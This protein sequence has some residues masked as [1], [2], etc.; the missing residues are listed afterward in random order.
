MPKANTIGVAIYD[1]FFFVHHYAMT[2]FFS[3]SVSSEYP[4]FARTPVSFAA[5]TRAYR[6]EGCVETAHDGYDTPRLIAGLASTARYH[7]HASRTGDLTRPIE[8][9]FTPL[10]VSAVNRKNGLGIRDSLF[11]T[12]LAWCSSYDLH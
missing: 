3:L 11:V 1:S 5:T 2:I 9:H 6:A 12:N 7:I 8:T 10:G 4:R